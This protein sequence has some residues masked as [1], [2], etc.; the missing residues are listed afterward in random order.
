M[1]TQQLIEAA[2]DWSSEWRWYSVWW[3]ADDDQVC[4]IAE[5]QQVWLEVEGRAASADKV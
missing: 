5:A 1:E 3:R 2:E 4:L